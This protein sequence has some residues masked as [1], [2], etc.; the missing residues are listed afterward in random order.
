LVSASPSAD[1]TAKC[2][3]R[4]HANMRDDCVPKTRVG[5]TFHN[6]ITRIV[7]R[8]TVQP[9]TAIIVHV[10]NLDTPRE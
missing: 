7:R 10:T 8:N 6:V 2:A 1:S 9:M 4:F 5:N 3:A